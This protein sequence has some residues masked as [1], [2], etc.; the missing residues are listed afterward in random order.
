MKTV[1][2]IAIGALAILL[3]VNT[4]ARSSQAEQQPKDTWQHLAL[5]QDDGGLGNGLGQQ[6]NKLGRE[7]WELVDVT[8]ITKNGTTVKTRYYFKRPLN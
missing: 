1:T 2:G 8:P 4:A 7:G 5:T 6:I 3:F